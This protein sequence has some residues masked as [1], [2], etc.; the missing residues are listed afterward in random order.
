M[1]W[2]SKDWLAEDNMFSPKRKVD[3]KLSWKIHH[4]IGSFNSVKMD[5]TVEYESLGECLFYSFLELDQSVIRYYV[6]PVEISFK[7]MDKSGDIR[8]WAHVPDVIVFRNGH[9]PYLFQ[10]K[11]NPINTDS[12]KMVNKR[13]EEY[14]EEKGWNYEVVYPKQLPQTI[15]RNIKFLHGAL[16]KRKWFDDWIPIIVMRLKYANRISIQ[17]L[18]NSFSSEV[19]PLYI[20]PIIYHLIAKGIVTTDLFQNIDQHS[21]VK[22][23]S[24][25]E[26]LNGFV[27]EEGEKVEVK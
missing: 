23:G 5:R 15:L 12:H 17:D 6:Q 21:E 4:L 8:E 24:L 3:N 9:E 22:I 7:S 19:S 16:K 26:Q 2:S 1:N 14:C 25:L 20:L 27:V 13:C 11:E 10:I 18:A